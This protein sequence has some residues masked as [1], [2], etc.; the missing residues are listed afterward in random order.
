MSVNYMYAKNSQQ[1]HVRIY[2]AKFIV[3]LATPTCLREFGEP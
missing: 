3:A 1:L 2:T